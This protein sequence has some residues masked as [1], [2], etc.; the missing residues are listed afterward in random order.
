MAEGLICY[1]GIDDPDEVVVNTQGRPMSPAD[2]IRVVDHADRDVASGEVGH[3]LTR[4][5]YTIRGYYAVP[6]HNAATFTADG[7]L[8]VEGRAKDLINRGGEKITAEE[9]E[10]LLLAHPAVFD[11]AVVGMPDAA[12]GERIC[13]FVIARGDRPRAGD[14]TRFLRA[15]GLAGY[16]IPDRIEFIDAFPQTGVGK[17]SRRALR[18]T[19]RALH[20]TAGAEA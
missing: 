6:E 7:C 1:T 20:F 11:V 16:K 13:A 8:V 9:V 12:Y 5:P 18:D 14:L 15:R 4:G 10:D 3:L 17:T 2:E 19:L